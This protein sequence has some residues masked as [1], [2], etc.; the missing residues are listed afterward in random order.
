MLKRLISQLTNAFEGNGG[1]A[2]LK[3]AYGRLQSELVHQRN[4][5]ATAYFTEKS[6]AEQF[7]QSEQTLCTWEKHV[8]VSQE[9]NNAELL[10]QVIESRTLYR[11]E[12]KDLETR[13]HDAKETLAIAQDY[14]TELESLVQHV[15]AI[16]QLL[17]AGDADGLPHSDS[18]QY[19]MRAAMICDALTSRKRSPVRQFQW[20]AVQA[21][22]AVQSHAELFRS[23]RQELAQLEKSIREHLTR[24]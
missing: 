8:N 23:A 1:S 4:S 18:A 7:T 13:L 2:R 9:K 14:L 15:H 16:V 17:D 6:L 11:D 22:A 19:K 24:H 10:S 20:F 5:I 21:K 12:H 3:A